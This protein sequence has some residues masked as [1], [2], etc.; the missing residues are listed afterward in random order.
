MLGTSES[1]H[2]YVITVQLQNKTNVLVN[3]GIQG[4]SLLPLPRLSIYVNTSA[5]LEGA[6]NNLCDPLVG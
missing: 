5:A 6:L 3:N 4:N 2:I 1:S